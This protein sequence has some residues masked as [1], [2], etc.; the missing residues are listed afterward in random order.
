MNSQSQFT[1][2]DEPMEQH[3]SHWELTCN[4]NEKSRSMNH[5]AAQQR[6]N[7]HLDIQPGFGMSR[8][9][10]PHLTPLDVEA[11]SAGACPA[12]NVA[13]E[14]SQRRLGWLRL[15]RMMQLNALHEQK[16]K[17]EEI[18]PASTSMTASSHQTSDS[19]SAEVS[20]HASKAFLNSSTLMEIRHPIVAV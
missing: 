8:L 16:S 6:R 1:P 3:P 19:H 13:E 2:D 7:T 9:S 11:M 10:D 18:S 17:S 20:W 15:M 14:Q 4:L 12:A 5:V